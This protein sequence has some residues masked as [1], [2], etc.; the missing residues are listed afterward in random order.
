VIDAAMQSNSSENYSIR[1]F[2][3]AVLLTAI[4]MVAIDSY[5]VNVAVISIQRDLNATSA[6]LQL[7]IVA[8]TAP[9]GVMLLNGA[10]LGDLFGRK[11]LF[12]IGMALFTLTSLMCALAPT[13]IWLVAS[14]L[15]QGLSAALLLPQVMASI[16]VMFDGHERQRAIG[17]VGAVN[18]IA[19][20]TA[21]ILGGV[22]IWYGIGGLGWR[23]IFL[24]NLPVGLAALVLAWLVLKEPSPPQG[25]ELDLKGSAL[26][27]SALSCLLV[28]FMVGQ[29]QG[30]PWW[31]IVVPLLSIP[32]FTYFVYFEGKLS[33]RGGSPLIDI[34]LLRNGHFLIG[35]LAVFLTL[36]ATP[37][38]VL[39]LTLLLQE[40][41]DYTAL[42]AALVFS[43][44]ALFYF[45]SSLLSSRLVLIFGKR[46]VV[47]AILVTA[48][49]HAIA[50]FVGL[51]AP[52]NP[53]L[54]AISPIVVSI[55]VGFVIPQCIAIVLA[56]VSKEHAGMGAGT[57]TTMQIVGGAI[58]TSIV[59]VL[60]FSIAH[61]TDPHS[62]TT[63][64]T[65]YGRGYALAL[66]YNLFATVLTL[67]CFVFLTRH[68]E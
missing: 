38:I 31:S 46:I 34:S 15:A 13:S 49:G 53:F 66:S 27:A 19:A 30:W 8:Y 59:G 21:Q 10:R 9:Y 40:G 51:V 1:W 62:A 23:L 12:L 11:R 48:C 55:G 20:S 54:L 6:E 68:K 65:I 4:F 3:L 41:L 18:G 25:S 16:R 61:S 26:A 5:I 50:I 58:G 28:P 56:Q 64:A 63:Q 35:V 24:V 67:P 45:V 33:A 14:R 37:T 42:Q 47:A 22:L 2:S 57:V 17:M 39:P 44:S 32:I 60:F 52:G 36:S 29:D 7:F 43:P